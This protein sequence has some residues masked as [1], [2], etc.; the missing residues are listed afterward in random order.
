MTQPIDGEP[1]PLT[2]VA[3]A[4]AA[5]DR[6]APPRALRRLSLT[7]V[8]AGRRYAVARFGRMIKFQPYRCL[9]SPFALAAAALAARGHP[10]VVCRAWLADRR[11]PWPSA[12][13]AAMGFNRIVDRRIDARNPRTAQQ[14]AP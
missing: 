3:D 8:A 4:A 6:P 12:R 14:R 7:P 2:A 1:G 13:T 5:D 9:R 10:P 11:S